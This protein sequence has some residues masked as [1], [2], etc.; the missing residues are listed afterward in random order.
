MTDV[1]LRGL[2]AEDLEPIRAAAAAAGSSV[3][4]YLR[5]TVHAQAVHLRRQAAITA[6]GQ[7][8]LGRA[9]VPEGERQAVLDTVDGIDDDR[10]D[11]LARLGR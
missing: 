1:L 10:G 6:A 11:Q 5:D 9:P 8:V 4:S 3:Q 7:R 2:P